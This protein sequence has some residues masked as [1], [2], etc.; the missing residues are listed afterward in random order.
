MRDST[1]EQPTQLTQF[2]SVISH[3]Q[4]SVYKWKLTSEIF[5]KFFNLN[6]TKSRCEWSDGKLK[7]D[8]FSSDHDLRQLWWWPPLVQRVSSAKEHAHRS[9]ANAEKAATYEKRSYYYWEEEKTEVRALVNDALSFIFQ[10]A[11][12]SENPIFCIPHHHHGPLF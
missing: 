8:V 4:N 11:M 6:Q 9:W 5:K 2:F 10:P 12:R 1:T 7:T 3:K